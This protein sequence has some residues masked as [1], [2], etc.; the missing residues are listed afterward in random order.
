LRFNSFAEMTSADSHLTLFFSFFIISEIE[1]SL[2]IKFLARP[3]SLV[4]IR[5]AA[6]ASCDFIREFTKFKEY[7]KL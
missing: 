7:K 6:K 1:F 4:L 3:F 2:S 5:I